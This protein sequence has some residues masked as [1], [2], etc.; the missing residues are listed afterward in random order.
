MLV[1]LCH[2]PC[3]HDAGWGGR[4]SGF[5]GRDDPNFGMM[6]VWPTCGRFS[7]SSTL[8]TQLASK[9]IPRALSLEIAFISLAAGTI[10]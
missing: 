4:L 6:I 2:R 10:R 8:F 9:Q 1:A 5:E 7:A 3:P